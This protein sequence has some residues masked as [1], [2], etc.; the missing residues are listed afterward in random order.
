M[1]VFAL[2]ER[3]LLQV[4]R[5][6]HDDRD[7]QD[8]LVQEALIMLWRLDVLT[9]DWSDRRVPT[10]CVSSALQSNAQHL[11]RERARQVTW[12]PAFPNLR[13][14]RAVLLADL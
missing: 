14:A 12:S 9:R 2:M 6:A 5:A 3:R 8:D 4:R 7:V 11:A 13:R 1:R 10:V